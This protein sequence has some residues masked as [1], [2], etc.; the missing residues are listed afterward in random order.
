MAPPPARYEAWLVPQDV[1]GYAGEGRAAHIFQT[2]AE[3]LQACLDHGCSSL[4]D[5]ALAETQWF[6]WQSI[7]TADDQ[8]VQASGGGKMQLYVVGV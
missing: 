6:D 3:A 1:C 2:R 7:H 8:Y 4:A 5:P